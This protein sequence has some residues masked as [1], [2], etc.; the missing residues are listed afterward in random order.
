MHP[1]NDSPKNHIPLRA[2]I[3]LLLITA[4]PI[5]VWSVVT[6]SFETRRFADGDIVDPTPT[7]DEE[8]CSSDADCPEG[9]SC[10]ATP[11]E[12]CPGNTQC[13][14][15]P[16]CYPPPD[17]DTIIPCSTDADCPISLSSP[18]FVKTIVWIK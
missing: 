2:L 9:Y 5:A 15:R 10:R 12:G 1:E 13:A 17:E 18:P 6:Q 4:I 14:H 7:P 8:F 11:W 3:V 16:F